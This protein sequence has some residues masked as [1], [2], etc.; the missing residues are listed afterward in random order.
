MDDEFGNGA[1][2]LF[3]AAVVHAACRRIGRAVSA[4]QARPLD[5]CAAE[6]MR[7]AL[8]GPVTAAQA[9]LRHSLA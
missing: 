7:E 6:Q 2:S 9:A 5:E 4:L 3:D 8:G 1:Q